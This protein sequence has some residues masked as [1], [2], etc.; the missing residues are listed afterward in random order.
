MTQCGDLL[1]R[2]AAHGKDDSDAIA[3]TQH[4]AEQW[5]TSVRDMLKRERPG[6]EAVFMSNVSNTPGM[7]DGSQRSKLLN[8]LRRREAALNSLMARLG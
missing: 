6:W 3:E 4:E 2:A 1:S 5:A 8:W 7:G